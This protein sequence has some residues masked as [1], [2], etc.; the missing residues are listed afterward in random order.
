MTQHAFFFA[1]TAADTIGVP[2]L[3]IPTAA[4]KK[5]LRTKLVRFPPLS[6]VGGGIAVLLLSDER[7]AVD[8]HQG[9][10]LRHDRVGEHARAQATSSVGRE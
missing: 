9:S 2:D 4:V 6:G 3:K 1:R 10:I 8:H 5:G 7:T